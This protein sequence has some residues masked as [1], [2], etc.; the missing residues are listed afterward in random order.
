MQQAV[1]LT[2]PDGAGKSTIWRNVGIKLYSE[3]RAK[4]KVI[5]Y[6]RY[7]TAETKELLQGVEGLKR[8]EIFQEDFKNYV[9]EMEE[10]YEAFPNTPYPGTVFMDR[11]YPCNMAY[12][13]YFNP[14]TPLEAFDFTPQMLT[15]IDKINIVHISPNTTLW[16]EKYNHDQ[17]H[18]EFKDLIE[19][20][21]QKVFLYLVAHYPTKI[22]VKIIYNRYD[23]Q[24]E[25]EVY[26]HFQNI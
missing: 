2:G 10:F 24:A 3:E 22:N 13:L 25:K 19:I 1:I 18:T 20:C 9:K 16:K 5:Y 17:L 4:G 14:D 11:M 6:K 23:G 8:H 7:P 21:Y 12:S 26:D 15:V